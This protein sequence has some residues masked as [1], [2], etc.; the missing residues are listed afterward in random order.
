MDTHWEWICGLND[1]LLMEAISNSQTSK[2]EIK[3]M[4]HIEKQQI[5][6]LFEHQNYK[7]LYRT[8]PETPQ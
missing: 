4:N 8:C 3:L 5:H 1:F 6:Y 7:E 2:E